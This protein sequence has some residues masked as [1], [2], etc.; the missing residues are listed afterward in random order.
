MLSSS[1]DTAAARVSS[2]LPDECGSLAINSTFSGIPKM[3]LVLNTE[4]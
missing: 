2:W 3:K 4:Q 1:M